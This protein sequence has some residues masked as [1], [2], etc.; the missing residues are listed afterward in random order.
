MKGLNTVISVIIVIMVGI[1]AV[2]VISTILSGN[3]GG[4]TEFAE[5]LNWMSG[6]L[7]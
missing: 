3:L 7:E 6:D 2:L 5:N 4:L 1:A